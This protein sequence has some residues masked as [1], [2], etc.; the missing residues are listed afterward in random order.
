[1]YQTRTSKVRFDISDNRRLSFYAALFGEEA[2]IQERD[3]RGQIV[4]YRE[5]IVPGAFT[6]T[7]A[8]D[9]EVIANIDH[10]PARTF[11]K[12]STGELLL[13]QDAH[14]LFCSCYLPSNELG[15]QII[16]DVKAG[17]LDGTSFRFAPTET[18]TTGD[19]AER[20]AV[21]L[22]D[23]C[24]TANPAYPQTKGEVHLRTNPDKTRL[25]LARYRLVRTKLQ[26]R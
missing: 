13:Q 10:D 8:T 18:R 22:A 25:L 6:R 21:E 19:L 15:D 20:V 2:T 3:N 9:A 12:R 26:N 23:V 4:S 5:V 16:R 17:K 1:M 24:I 7:L 11:A 14:G